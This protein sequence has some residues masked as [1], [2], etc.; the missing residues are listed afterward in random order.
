[1]SIKKKKKIQSPT[2]QMKEWKYL[3]GLWSYNLASDLL[4]SYKNTDMKE[5]LRI[6]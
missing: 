6:H 5:V 2:P 4:N 1:M 3:L